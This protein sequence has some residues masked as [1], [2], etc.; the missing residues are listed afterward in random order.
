MFHVKNSYSSVKEKLLGEAIR[1]TKHYFS[2]TS[3]EVEAIFYTM[4]SFY[5]TTTNRGSKQEKATY[6]G[7]IRWGRSM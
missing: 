6:H 5:I 7:R 1:F 2:I 4:K 3:K